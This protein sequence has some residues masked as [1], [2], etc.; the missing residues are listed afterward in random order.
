MKNLVAVLAFLCCVVASSAFA[1]SKPADWNQNDWVKFIEEGVQ[2]GLG[3]A[4]SKAG[5]AVPLVDVYSALSGL[6]GVTKVGMQEWLEG[7][8]AEASDQNNQGLVERYQ[9]YHSCLN[10]DC[11]RLRE[12]CTRWDVSGRWQI[13][14]TNGYKPIFNLRQNGNQL[15]GQAT[16]GA[17]A[18]PVNGS[19]IDNRFDVLVDW[20]NNSKG[21][22]KGTVRP[23]M[24]SNGES[25]DEIHPESRAGWS[26]TGPAKCVQQ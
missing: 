17:T 19:L 9:A 7:K 21:R 13:N 4:L 23:G 18:A 20:S 14:Q 26:G 25:Y 10:G 11:S 2:I 16:L 24:I 3:E 5:S 8:I 1:L 6:G 12:L 22:Y 15:E